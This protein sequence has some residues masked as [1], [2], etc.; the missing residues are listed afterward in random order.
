ML[1][2]LRTRLTAWYVAVLA[3]T[4]ILF[5]LAVYAALS[6]SLND[7]VDEALTSSI[8]ITTTSLSNDIGEG[9]SRRDAARATVDE[10]SSRQ[11]AVAVFDGNGQLLAARE[12]DD[13]LR[14]YLPGDCEI[15]DEAPRLYDVAVDD[16]DQVRVGLKRVR[17]GSDIAPFIVHVSTP[18]EPIEDDLEYMR[19]M[20]LSSIPLVL[21]VAGGAGW[22]MAH[23]ALEPM[24][25]MAERARAIG[26][27]NLD[28]RLPITNP[29]DEL[30]RLAN[31]FNELLS[32]ISTAFT[33]QRQFMADASHELKT[34]LATIRAATDV[35]LQ[36][37][38]RREDEYRDALKMIDD[39]AQRLSRIVEDMFTLA[40]A[41]A[42]HLPLRYSSFYLDELLTN[43][44]AAAAV[45]ARRSQI[46]VEVTGATDVAC[47]GD[48]DLIR[49][50]VG[51]LV[52]NAVR[53]SPAGATVTITLAR[54]RERARIEV[55][56]QGS[57]IPEE[58][59]PHIFERFYR[60]DVARPRATGSASG[61]GL[62]LAIA[63]WIAEA[64]DGTLT[65]ASSSPDGSV[66]AAELPCR[67]RSS[68]V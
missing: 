68:S 11:V 44:A 40:R 60:A 26:A 35:T 56:D 54:E 20:L 49:R 23:K 8:E 37:S 12:G 28:Q 24:M 31:T 36:Q 45:R 58:A 47:V 1:D 5:E 10:L 32:R 27:T 61:A 4:L 46:Q 59:W 6:R 22:F 9:Q 29:R 50:L 65:L 2:T 38:T 16:D 52:D 21:L 55:A 66:F 39:Q 43:V 33:Q 14:P 15:P 34:P 17:V 42:G 18:L 53:Y 64:H 63:R 25:L 7:G 41:D 57:G 19:T 48:E 30:G 3:V 13:E 62:G 67:G 51:N